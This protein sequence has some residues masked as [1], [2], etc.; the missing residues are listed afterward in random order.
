MTPFSGS[1]IWKAAGEPGYWNGARDFLANR[2]DKSVLVAD[3]GAT[4]V[5]S[6]GPSA[7]AT[8]LG[9][10]FDS[11]D[12]V[13]LNA[14][15]TTTLA[16]T[17]A[18]AAK[19]A[20]APDGMTDRFT[21]AGNADDSIDYTFDGQATDVG[22]IT[23]DRGTQAA[24]RFNGSTSKIV[25][26][27][28]GGLSEN[29]PVEITNGFTVA[30]WVKLAAG[31]NTGGSQTVVAQNGDNERGFFL[32]YDR[33]TQSWKFD[34]QPTDG[35]TFSPVS[36]K[37]Q[38]LTGSQFSG[39]NHLAGV[40][41]ASAHTMNLYVNGVLVASAPFTATT[42]FTGSM[43]I[44]GAAKWQ[45]IDTDFLNGDISDVVVYNGKA[46]DLSGVQHLYMATAQSGSLPPVSGSGPTA[47]LTLSAN[48]V[49]A[50]K[51]VTA[52]ASGST[53][54]TAAI[55]G[56]TVDFG[57]GTVVGPQTTASAS[58]TYTNAGTYTYTVKLTVTDAA[59]NIAIT[60]APITVA[61]T[62][63]VANPGFETGSLAGWP[64]SYS[65][66]VAA[67]PR[68]GSYAAQITVPAGQAT[69]AA[70]EQVISGLTP[71][72]RYHLSG[73]VRTDGGT[74]ILGAKGFDATGDDSSNVTTATDWVQI[75]NP[76]T[77]GPA[78]TS[79]D[80][81]C[82]R[83][84]V[85]TSSCDDIQVEPVPAT[86]GAVTNTGLETGDLAGWTGSYQAGLT[87]ANPHGGAYAAL[88]TAPAGSDAALE[89]VVT[90]LTPNTTYTL[91][92][93]VRTDGGTT[94][95]GAKD[96]NAAT[97][98]NEDATTTSTGWTLLTDQFTTGATDTSVDIYCYR[99]TA[100]ASACDDITLTSP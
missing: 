38:P 3:N 10:A 42:S 53:A 77:T 67:A 33:G 91:R 73:W 88:I 50:G 54:G 46:L 13:N 36:V 80:V 19:W 74:T 75:N 41:N 29:G 22:W 93:W 79:V 60:T 61:P 83:S 17:I 48:P 70:V 72:T 59:G 65:A 78:G 51:P 76:F 1:A 18:A 11:G 84:S 99:S 25:I 20:A 96:Y 49:L 2:L 56:Y 47:R 43:V 69:G 58:H 94:I 89:Q 34:M 4:S 28:P 90:G 57:D 82:Y 45:T 12:K 30:A 23:N 64:Q 31:A 66:T 97:G 26:P 40:Y 86:P 35:A 44:G 37:S 8:V 6:S 55:T 98:D 24:A 21:L 62:G 52:D 81:F 15:G 9:A 14:A 85:G 27:I 32:G 5:L 7:A 95:L 68:S 16:D 100:G 39:W 92:G 87:T 71:N 63:I